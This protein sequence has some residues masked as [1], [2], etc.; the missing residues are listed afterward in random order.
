MSHWRK[1]YDDRFVGSW[2][3]DGKETFTATIKELKL[4]EMRD[5]DGETIRK[6]V[7]YF[8]KAKKGMV[9]NK[10]NA[11]TIADLYG[12]NTDTWTG[13][14][15]VLFATMCKAFGKDVECVRVKNQIPK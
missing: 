1:L 6:P 4:E 13:K 7:L 5:H 9:L 3:F 11:R 15:I 14:K 12:S 8:D 10:T 2:D